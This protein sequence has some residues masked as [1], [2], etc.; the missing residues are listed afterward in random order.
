M[1]LWIR[2]DAATPRDPQIATLAEQLRVE[3]PTA[4]GH[5]LMLWGVMAEHAASGD[6]SAVGDATLERWAGWTKRRGK[7]A[8]AFRA[9]F[10]GDDGMLKGW[11]ER[12]GAL[13]TRMER[14]RQRWHAKKAEPAEPPP[15]PREDSPEPPQ[16]L[17]G[18]SVEVLP[19]LRADSASTE[20]NGTVQ[21][22]KA[23]SA[24]SAEPQP[25]VADPAPPKPRRA[26]PDRQPAERGG[27][28][29]RFHALLESRGMN[30]PVGQ[31][32]A[33]LKAPR[34]RYGEERLYEALTCFLDDGVRLFDEKPQFVTLPKFAEFAGKWVEKITPDDELA[35]LTPVAAHGAVPAGVAP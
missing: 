8:P 5:V 22:S 6:L 26:K 18:V 24:T 32:G 1:K 19:S 30:Y 28:P 3:L 35:L 23:F 25:A 33:L 13:L 9:L 14:D 27:W 10:V 11:V 15:P 16:K 17:R 34:E 4:L 12:Q 21:R 7:F 29:A 31:I 20:R 2:V